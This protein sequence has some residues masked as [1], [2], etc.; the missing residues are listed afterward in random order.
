MKEVYRSPPFNLDG[1]I[2]YTV[3]YEDNSRRTTLQHR[4]TM[5][6]HLGRKLLAEEHVHHLNEKRADNRLEN[7]K[8]LSREEHGRLHHK[9]GE[10]MTLLVCVECDDLFEVKLKHEKFRVKANRGGPYCGRSCAGKANQ[11]LGTRC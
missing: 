3:R 6:Q 5:E 2:A 7:L 8:V 1:Y 4:E 9:K 11:R 10:T